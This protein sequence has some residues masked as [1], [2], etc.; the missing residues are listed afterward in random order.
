VTLTL[1]IFLVGAQTVTLDNFFESLKR[2]DSP[3]NWLV[4]PADFVIKPDVVAPVFE[5]PVSVL[6]ATFK[7]IVLR[8]KGAA[9]VEESANG[10]H[11]VATTQLMK[12]KDDIRVLFIPVAPNK[13]TIALY[14]ASRVGSWDMGTNRRRLETWIDQTQ[15][16]LANSKK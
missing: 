15:E 7:S 13:S 14:S 11:V 2:P 8:S 3:N 1:F 4:A 6:S 16:A 10:L 9:V 5:A 12:F